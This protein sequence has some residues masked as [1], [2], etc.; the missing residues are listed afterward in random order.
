MRKAFGIIAVT[1][2][3]G[4]VFAA[5]CSSCNNNNKNVAPLASNWYTNTSY[6]NIQPT[7]IEGN[8][9]FKTK[10]VITYDVNFVKPSLGNATYSVEYT[11]GS[12]TTEFYATTFN[13]SENS[14]LIHADHKSGYTGKNI[15][16]YY[17]KTTFKADITYTCGNDDPKTFE[18]SSVVTECYF[19]SV[20]NQLRP[21]YSKQV[22]NS[23][24]PAALQATSIDACY[25]LFDAVYENFYT[26][27]GKSVITKIEDNVNS[28]NSG[29]TKRGVGGTSHSLFDVTTLD[30]ALRALIGS[31]FN[32]TIQLYSPL[33][34][35]K[36]FTLSSPSTAIGNDE[37]KA[38]IASKLQDKG[39]YVPVFKDEKEVGLQTKA[40]TVTSNTQLSGVSQTYWFAKVENKRNN[41]GR[42]TLLKISL[43]I[44]FNLGT[45]EYNIK[46]V[47]STLWNG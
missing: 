29:E 8:D 7:F 38:A 1:L 32:Q 19:L 17:Y 30:I 47:S 10:E 43:P 3:T 20:E 26:Y 12:Y 24:S 14:T 25:T 21:L 18:N 6:R 37:Q 15:I 31:S 22:V 28:K 35:I 39:L 27:N 13:T 33:N 45:L 46:E 2:A 44:V 11:N 16:A 23:P 5:G 40:V 36:T 41:I 9:L 4:C 42:A 34:A